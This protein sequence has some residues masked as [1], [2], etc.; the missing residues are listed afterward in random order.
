MLSSLLSGSQVCT[1]V[2]RERLTGDLRRS[3]GQTGTEEY[4]IQGTTTALGLKCRYVLSLRSEP[5]WIVLILSTA[6]APS[7]DFL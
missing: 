4:V 2:L 5:Y 3:G 1:F 6:G 7:L